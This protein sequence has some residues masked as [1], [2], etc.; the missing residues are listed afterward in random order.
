MNVLNLNSQQCCEQW[1]VARTLHVRVLYDEQDTCGAQSV[2]RMF[3][4]AREEKDERE[5]KKLRIQN[6]SYN[7]VG[8][9]VDR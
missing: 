8:R 5:A 6:S 9:A 4:T 2:G 7:R 1:L 3:I